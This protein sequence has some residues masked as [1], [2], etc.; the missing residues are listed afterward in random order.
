MR[1]I[2]CVVSLLALAA[3]SKVDDGICE[4]RGPGGDGLSFDADQCLGEWSKKL[5]KSGDTATEVAEAVLH[6]CATSI[7]KSPDAVPGLEV[8][9]SLDHVWAEAR[10]TA[11]TFVVEE[12][13]GHCSEKK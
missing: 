3:C 10:R 9:P 1:R 2:V 12:R 4:L 6:V 8:K 5:S 11:V 13:A 7:N